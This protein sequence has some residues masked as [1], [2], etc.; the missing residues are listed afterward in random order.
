MKTRNWMK[1]MQAARL[2]VASGILLGGDLSHAGPA[3]PVAVPAPPID[4]PAQGYVKSEGVP[5]GTEIA[6]VPVGQVGPAWVVLGPASTT[7][8][9]VTVPPNNQIAGAINSL[10]IHPTNPDIIYIGAV[11]GGIW[12]TAN[13][14]AASPTWFPLTDNLASKSIG[15][16]EFDPTDATNQTLVAGSG[17]LSSYGAIGQA[18]IG[19]LRTTDGGNTW[20]VLATSTFVNENLMSIAAR[21]SI[22]M[23]ASDSQWGGGTGSGVFRSTST[24][25]SFSLVSGTAGLA[26]GPVSDM[27]GDPGNQSRFFAAVRTVGIFR[28]DDT[29]ATWTNVT[30]NLTGISATTTKVEMAM[31]NNGTTTALY[32]AVLNSTAVQGIWR[33]TDLGATW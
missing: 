5:V 32:V 13:A 21:G 15:A 7:G 25:A 6:P 30:N 28:S 23:A 29:G 33:S 18:R 10:A 2:L 16:L 4:V 24:G 19:V 12:R 8:G 20:S 11:N 31:F 3:V 27:I 22:I 1:M 14:T 26:A 17:R 9:Q